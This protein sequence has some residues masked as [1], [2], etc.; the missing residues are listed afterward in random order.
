MKNEL[1]IK[2]LIKRLGT[3]IIQYR[4]NKSGNIY[5]YVGTVNPTKHWTDHKPGFF[6]KADYVLASDS[7]NPFMTHTVFVVNNTLYAK[8]APTPSSKILYHREGRFWLRDTTMFYEEA[9]Q[10][11][12]A[13]KPRFERA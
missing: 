7:E 5:D 4:H 6:A 13:M 9:E 1:N 3:D 10:P 2:T 8:G 11:D 12:G